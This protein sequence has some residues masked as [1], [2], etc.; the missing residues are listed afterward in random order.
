[1]RW[2]VCYVNEWLCACAVQQEVHV[3]E[4][5]YYKREAEASAAEAPHSSPFLVL[6]TPMGGELYPSLSTSPAAH[7]FLGGV[8]EQGTSRRGTGVDFDCFC[9]RSSPAAAWS[10]PS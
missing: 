2:E 1:M 7:Q 3:P 5:V 10:Y 9:L 4:A 8:P 6:L